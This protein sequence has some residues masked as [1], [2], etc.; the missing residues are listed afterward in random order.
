MKSV[1]A[2]INI[3]MNCCA[4]GASHIS[5]IHK[6]LTC[7][8]LGGE[9]LRMWRKGSL[10]L[11]F[12][13]ALRISRSADLGYFTWVS[14]PLKVHIGF[15]RYVLVNHDILASQCR[16]DVSKH[17]KN[18]VYVTQVI[19]VYADGNLACIVVKMW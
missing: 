6:E 14:P 2:C 17:E 18:T 16:R 10:K 12:I 7:N 8:P 11:F 9:K 13:V 1:P 5:C 4:V 3:L 15:T 19:F